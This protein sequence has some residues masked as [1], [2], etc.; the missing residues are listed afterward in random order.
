MRRLEPEPELIPGRRETRE[1][2]IAAGLTDDDIDQLT[3]RA[4]REVE[5]LLPRAP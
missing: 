4:Q 3:K 1:L 2:V 5:P